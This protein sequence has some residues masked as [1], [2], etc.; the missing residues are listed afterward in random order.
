[1]ERL[2]PAG[3]VSPVHS[4]DVVS[5]PLGIGFEKLD[6]AVFDPEK[7]YDKVAAI[8]VKWIR[9]QS[10]WART[11]RTKGA[12]DF[13]WI[14]TVVDN[15]LSRG[16]APWVCLCYGNGLYDEKAAKVFGAV[17]VPPIF[18]QEQRSA[19]HAYVVA[20][21]RHFQGRVQWYEVWNEPDGV[22]CWKHGP[23][24]VEY[25]EFLKATAAA[26]KAG[27][28]AA[29]IMGG[30]TCLRGM[31]WIAD[32]FS[33]GAAACMDWLT[34]H[35][36]DH[37]ELINRDRVAA[38]RALCKLH[39]PNLEVVQ[40]ETGT[41]SR[42]DGA[43][44]LAGGA[45]TPRRQAKYVA[46]HVLVDLF[47]RMQLTSYFS[48]MDMIEALNGTIGD[49]ASYLD[50]GYFGV[51]GATFD[52][53]GIA[54]GDYTPKP[55]YTTLQTLA[56]I[57]REDFTVTA[58]PLQFRVGIE[59][60]RTMAREDLPTDV[61]CGGFRKPN[62]SAAFA[63]WKSTN[64]MTTDYDATISM[65]CS[66]IGGDVRLVDLVDGTIYTLPPSIQQ[67]TERGVRRFS[68]LPLK[69]YPLLLAFG[70]FL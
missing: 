9:L 59:S 45:W 58:L 34:Y 15:L 22:W 35:A 33:T 2:I 68:H 31:E 36:Y 46:R 49:K 4:R 5:S 32:V 23:N 66:G 40:G 25:G 19:W 60:R 42:S 12:Y 17:G 27:D 69:D 52:A 30:S 44:A 24:G 70:D 43:G 61:V 38:L 41:Q 6:R 26:V 67:D 21:T 56:S 57:F 47:D 50:Y 53:N 1:M 10:G 29:K 7:A 37:S 20:F 3:R 64:L 63:Y 62:G 65:E 54:T 14:D 11:E 51:L 55:S 28:P 18:T 48:C 8:G 13:A 39:N 16:L